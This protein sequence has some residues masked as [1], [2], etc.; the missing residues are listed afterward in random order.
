MTIAAGAQSATFTLAVTGSL[1]ASPSGQLQVGIDTGTGGLPVVGATA[2]TTLVNANAVPGVAAQPAFVNPFDV[3]TLT[4]S[5]N[6]WTLAL[7]A[8]SVDSTSPIVAID[9][10]NLASAP[11]DTLFG[12]LQQSGT[13]VTFQNGLPPIVGLDPGQTLELDATLD[14][15]S[16]GQI[17][18]TVTFDANE[19]NS[20]GYSA[21]LTPITLTITADVEPAAAATINTASPIVFGNVHQ[22]A[23]ANEALSVTNSASAGATGLDASFSSA[24]AGL[25]A[26]GAITQL[27]PQATDTT[28]LRRRSRHEFGGRKIGNS[29]GQFRRGLRRRE[30]VASAKPDRAGQR[31]RLPAR[32]SGHRAALDDRACQ[33]SRNRR[34]CP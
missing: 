9:V 16:P 26:T 12:K 33:R 27:A 10:A 29:D 6:D 5:G 4:Q 24:P 17:D 32:R 25:T 31:R 34:F 21:A 20:S 30:D 7:G 1:D 18:E 11:A 15:S 3:G 22:G 14:T 19:R 13:G 2:S 8:I 28:D 23:A